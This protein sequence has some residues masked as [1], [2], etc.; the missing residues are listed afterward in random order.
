MRGG[1]AFVAILKTNFSLTAILLLL[2]GA[3]FSLPASSARAAVHLSGIV[4]S[5]SGEP[6]EGVAVSVRATG[7]TYTTTV[8]SDH[9]GAYEFPA[10]GN[11]VYRVWAQAVGF[12][13]A[14]AQVAL[15]ESSGQVP[16]TLKKVDDYERQL[17]GPELMASFGDGSAADR[18]MKEI[19]VDNCT[20]CHQSGFI[21]Q[22]RFDE[23]GWGVIIQM[24]ERFT[25]IGYTPPGAKPSGAMQAYKEELASYLA[26][27]RGPD[28]PLTL[29]PYPRPSGEAA[30]IVIT[31]YDLP[32]P[33]RPPGWVMPHDG[34][35]WWE[36]V[37]SR[38]EG[39]APHDVVVD[40][41]G[42]LWFADDSTPDRTLAKLDPRTGKVTDYKFPDE[43][44]NAVST[45]TLL[46][47]PD[48][49]LWASSE[50]LG[51]PIRF[52]PETKT[53][54]RFDRPAGVP[55]ATGFLAQDAEGNLWA[56]NSD[57]VLKLDAKTGMFTQYA[58]VTHGKSTY[59]IA[60]DRQD[61]VWVAQ[62]TVDKLAMVDAGTGK[63]GELVL[64]PADAA[65]GHATAR[66]QEITA[67]SEL[68]GSNNGT[69]LLKGPRRLAADPSADLL[70]AAEYFGNSLLKVETR[71]R[72][73]TEF[74]LPHRYSQPYSVAVDKN[75]DVWLTLMNQDRIAKFDPG[76][77]KFTEYPLPTRGTEARQIYADNRTDPP[78]IWVPY[79]RT[80]K[81]A[82]IQFRGGKAGS[83]SGMH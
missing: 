60:V 44:N 48:G 5:S 55:P 8:Y 39:R 78:T 25:A 45:H 4:K 66:D 26:K 65:R 16:L 64:K 57:G 82:R 9:Q 74:P 18:R 76:T 19:L 71:T 79:N 34:S 73:V 1:E 7:K 29:R 68:L 70:W 42:N 53:F 38:Y 24:M 30:R 62:P 36:G 47:G 12:R 28:S 59:D 69:P 35:D 10:L 11:G 23:R 52:D 56:P 72:K 80:N 20:G 15:A 43:K 14:Q 2:A 83:N 50:S 33:D 61:Q 41:A 31:E 40:E 22:N 77:Q 21:L 51:A 32:R 17:T 13:N 37:P 67:R 54:R 63:A 81:I 75:H 27:V 46:R 58:T 6:L 49:I 3:V